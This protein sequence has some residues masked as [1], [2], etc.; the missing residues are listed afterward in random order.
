MFPSAF[1]KRSGP[2]ESRDC[3][4]ESDKPGS[5]PLDRKKSL[6]ELKKNPDI[7][8]KFNKVKTDKIDKNQNFL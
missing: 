3:F 1:Q 5:F 4:S 6:N 7:D 8:E 2:I